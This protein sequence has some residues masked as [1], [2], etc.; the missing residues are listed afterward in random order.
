MISSQK[1]G[2]QENYIAKNLQVLNDVLGSS[3][4]W[5]ESEF[6]LAAVALMLLIYAVCIIFP[7][8]RR[9][10][11]TL[12]IGASIAILAWAVPIITADE[13]RD[14]Y[15]FNGFA[16]FLAT[17][18]MALLA[19]ERHGRQLSARVLLGACGIL[20]LVHIV[21]LSYK[22]LGTYLLY[23]PFQGLDPTHHRNAA[24][25]EAIKA[26]K[27]PNFSTTVLVDQHSYID[28]REF[29]RVGLEPKYVNLRNWDSITAGL[30]AGKDYVVVFGR[31]DYGRCHPLTW[32][33]EWTSDMMRAYDI[34]QERL[35][36]LKEVRRYRGPA[37]CLL[38][39]APVIP[40]DD[41]TV[42]VFS[43]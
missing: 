39:L 28:L 23:E 33:G 6:T 18:G 34:Y 7:R 15:L 36:R 30:A 24:T 5:R 26:A 20:Y 32:A 27:E 9:P 11:Q 37:Q 2:A 14:R 31:G 35:S 41:M 42:A 1:I 13:V 10:A 12:A 16:A 38:S 19:L 25:L 29:R 3:L 43:P 4:L 40:N 21:P 8:T 17:S 22:S